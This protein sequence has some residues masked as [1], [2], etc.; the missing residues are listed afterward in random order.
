MRKPT[1]EQQPNK[2]NTT[3]TRTTD[4]KPK[5]AKPKPNKKRN[6]TTANK[7]QDQPDIKLFL[8]QKK[9]EI[10]ARAAANLQPTQVRVKSNLSSQDVTSASSRQVD[11]H[12]GT[13]TEG[14]P[15]QMTL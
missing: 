12:G 5:P 11:D 1:K 4:H 8:A 7:S 15:N 2:N 9:L 14:R 6:P 10:K 13:V 3:T